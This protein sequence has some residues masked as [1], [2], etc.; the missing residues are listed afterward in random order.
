MK[1]D[2]C[3]TAEQNMLKEMK[4]HIKNKEDINKRN[5]Y[6]HVPL[7]LAIIRGHEEMALLLL[8]HGA[9]PTLKDNH[10]LNALHISAQEQMNNVA[11]IIIG[12]SPE[13]LY[14]ECKHGAQP[15]WYAVHNAKRPFD[16]IKLFLEKGADKDHGEN[17]STAF[18]R[19]KDYNIDE[20]VALFDGY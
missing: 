2:I 1:L 16:I 14:V 5:N 12:K 18:D 10:G 3:D 7:L 9:D 15:L 13:S 8:E 17:G 11:K 4:K 6:G 20:V 19:A